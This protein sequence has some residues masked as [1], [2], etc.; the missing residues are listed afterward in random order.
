MEDS[1]I[2][3]R[4]VE[5]H[6]HA[7]A[8]RLGPRRR[9]TGRFMM[10]ARNPG[11]RFRISARSNTAPKTAAMTSAD[12]ARETL[13]EHSLETDR[14]SSFERRATS[15]GERADQQSLIGRSVEGATVAEETREILRHGPRF[16][17]RSTGDDH[18]SG[19]AKRSRRCGPAP[20]ARIDCVRRRTQAP[21]SSR[22]SHLARRV[23]R[24]ASGAS[25]PPAVPRSSE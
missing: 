12:R 21:S 24:G 10:K 5:E 25:P 3:E 17:H 14:R 15:G 9:T 22:L 19:C 1:C 16:L 6:D 7:A 18:G 4:P 11:L 8:D 2:A 13:R 23:V 20:S